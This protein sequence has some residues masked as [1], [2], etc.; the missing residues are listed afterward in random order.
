VKIKFIVIIFFLGSLPVYAQPDS[1]VKVRFAL[2]ARPLNLV[3]FYNGSMIALGVEY[4]IKSGT[5][6]YNELGL[7][8]P[9]FN[10]YGVTQS[11]R[12]FTVKHE[13]KRYFDSD[14]RGSTYCSLLALGSHQRYS[15][16]DSIG[17]D[18]P[19]YAVHYDINRTYA[20][21]T[22]QI[23]E[24][25]LSGKHFIM[26]WSMGLGLIYNSV[27][28]TGISE[29]DALDRDLGDWNVPTN[30]IQRCGNHVAPRFTGGL[31][32]GYRIF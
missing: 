2:F 21:A 30:W 6:C 17:I 5:T 18:D 29:R 15:R 7:F 31:K 9:G 25:I 32:I 4:K 19:Q 16:T 23:G 12:G 11:H 10:A 8:F 13:I 22:I 1:L 27:K 3:D 20:G 24:M 26:D 28:C 14:K